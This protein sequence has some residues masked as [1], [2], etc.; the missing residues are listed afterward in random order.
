M[1]QECLNHI[2]ET[3]SRFTYRTDEKLYG[4]EEVW[5]GG[6]DSQGLGDCEDYALEIR[7]HCGGSIYHCQYSGWGHAVLKLPNGQWIDN[8]YKKPVDELNANY[9][10]LYKYP[11]WKIWIK[12]L[13]GWFNK[14]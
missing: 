6:L 11:V 3:N 14:K 2:K 13:V 8:I 12:L 1:K 10:G 7:K 5:A 9:T 4:A